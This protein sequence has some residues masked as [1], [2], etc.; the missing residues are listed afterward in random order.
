MLGATFPLFLLLITLIAGVPI[1]MALSL[2]GAFGIWWVTGDFGK[3]LGIASLVPYTSVADYGLTPLPMFMF[4]A[5]C[6][7]SAGFAREL[8]EACAAWMSRIKGGLA[9]ASVVACGVFGAMSGASTAT[10]S[11]MAQIAFPEMRRYGYSDE[12]SAGSIGVGATIVVL[13]PPSISMMI[14]GIAT[15]TSIGKLLIAGII[16]AILTAVVLMLCIMVWV[17]LAPGHAP[18]TY[19]TTWSEKLSLIWRIWPC[20]LL[21]GC[22]IFGL[23][24]GVCT[25]TEDAALGAFLAVVLGF[26]MRR[27]TIGTALGALKSMAR[28]AVMIFTIMIGANLFGYYM[29]LSGIAGDVVQFVIDGGYNRWV[30]MLGI[31]VGYFVISMFM[32]EIPL[33][34]LTL[35][36]TFPLIV[37]LGFDPVWFGIMSGLMMAMGLVF[38][39]VGLIAFVVAANARCDLTKVYVGTGYLIVS[40]F[41]VTAL[42]MFFPEIALW[43]P[44][45]MN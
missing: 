37:K 6:T 42:L 36:L 16:P 30:V 10:S 27:L 19:K 34:L 35:P 44:N 9:M 43:L 2:C 39:P 24:S 40:L 4:M 32:D 7:A 5:F 1:A 33:L 38:P 29:T 12:L 41:I 28:T 15:Q 3:V 8:Y 11:V 21:I 22:I 17:R 18:A 14:Y 13:I 25:P 26:A 20:I 45:Q 23:Y 31:I